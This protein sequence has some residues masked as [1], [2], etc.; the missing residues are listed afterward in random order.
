MAHPPTPQQQAIFDIT[1]PDATDNVVVEAVAGSGKTTTLLGIVER[2]PDT[3]GIIIAFNSDIAKELA[4]RLP[5]REMS[6]G[7]ENTGWEAKTVHAT[8]KHI[9]DAVF[10]QAKLEKWKVSNIARPMVKRLNLDWKD[11][12]KVLGDITRL[13][14]LTKMTLTDPADEE[15]LWK[16]VKYYDLT[17]GIYTNRDG[18]IGSRAIDLLPYVM[19]AAMDQFKEEGLYDFDD[20]VYLPVALGLDFPKKKKVLVDESQDLNKIQYVFSELLAEEGAQRVYVGDSKQSIYGFTGADPNS[21][22][23]IIEWSGATLRP[24]SVCFRCPIS[25][26][27]IA[28]KMVPQIQPRVNAPK[29]E[30]LKIAK[31]D[32]ALFLRPGDMVLS[33][34]NA[35]LLSACVSLL[36][37]GKKARIK[38]VDFAQQLVTLIAELGGKKDA[39]YN[40]KALVAGIVGWEAEERET[41]VK[42][43]ASE[44]SVKRIEDLSAAMQVCVKMFPNSGTVERL[45]ENIKRMFSDEDE[46]SYVWFSSI[47][48]AKGLEKDNIFIIEPQNLPLIFHKKKQQAWEIEQ[49]YNLKYVAV[50]RAMKRLVVVHGEKTFTGYTPEF[51]RSRMFDEFCEQQYLDDH[52]IVHLMDLMR[53]STRERPTMLTDALSTVKYGHDS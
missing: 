6:F 28:V 39:A 1:G 10:P 47:H 38:G 23:N 14:K 33:R 37:D 25:V 36:K 40:A 50:T 46:D 7:E 22:S 26:L 13:V 11:Q 2:N 48:K 5:K 51:Y 29:G 18:S 30:T 20:M 4:S 17:K 41:L 12:R 52:Q 31:E 44:T 35:P 19:K 43:D 34:T 32:I 42:M 27:Q 9:I 45:G 49:E 8:G 53:L 15:G 24:L 21:F 16:I 3:S